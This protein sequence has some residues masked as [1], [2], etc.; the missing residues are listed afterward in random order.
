[1]VWGQRALALKMKNFRNASEVSTAASRL[2]SHLS[3]VS[4]VWGEGSVDGAVY[5]NTTAMTSRL[6]LAAT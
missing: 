6:S 5:V 1:M 3:G 2:P 4:G